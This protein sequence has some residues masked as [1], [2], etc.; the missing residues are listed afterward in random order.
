[1][2]T[3]LGKELRR[4]KSENPEKLREVLEQ[5][6]EQEAHAILYDPEIWLRPKQVVKDEWPEPIIMFLGGRGMGK[7][8]L[9]VQHI[10]KLV[11]SNNLVGPIAIIC[12]TQSDA[13]H[14]MTI[15]GILAHADPIVEDPEYQPSKARIVFKNGN[16]AR[17]FSAETGAE[18]V[19]G[20]NNEILII[21]EL[22]SF[23][24]EDVFNQAMLT[25]RVGQSKCII[26][27]TPRPTPVIID[28]YK[29][30]VFNDDP[31]QEGKDVRII[32]G[33]T[34]DNFENLSDA[35]KN[36]IIKKYEGTRLGAQELEGKLLLDNEAALW[37][38]DLIFAQTLSRPEDAPEMERIS[39]GVD[40]AVS[41][42]KHSDLTGIV[43]SGRGEDQMG[44]VLQDA[45][46]KYTSAQWVQKVLDLYDYY[47]TTTP[48]SITVEKNQGGQLITDALTRNR[49]F[50]PVDT[51]FSSKSKI[52][53]AEPIAMLYE[54]GKIWH[55][56]SFLELEQEMVSYEGRGREKSP[57]H[58]DALVFSMM[59]VLPTK[60]KSLKSFE[61]LI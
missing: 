56:K 42:G 50:L 5:L 41:T 9:S 33:S 44:Y 3:S 58:L 40:P 15:N 7:T 61:M 57:D 31:P 49:P 46:G 21:D 10:R 2:S 45:T 13:I 32:T 23:A 27:T 19:R 24:D 35:F 55:V 4:L 43:V 37:T 1:M 59:N 38:T 29:R 51:V 47:S 22:G 26:T 6:S 20:S 60:K 36:T 18:R 25:L 17:L 14:T 16:V 30:A 11:R 8:Y 28:L 54:Q 48:T 12:P 52:A 53:R 39:I 34:Y